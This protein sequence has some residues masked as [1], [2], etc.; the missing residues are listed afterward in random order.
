ML[1]A[2]RFWREQVS[3]L[4]YGKTG[5]KKRETC[6]AASLE[7][8]LMNNDVGR[9]TTHIKPVWQQIM[10]LTGLNMG[11]KTRNIF[12]LVDKSS[13]ITIFAFFYTF[14]FKSLF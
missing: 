7:N 13:R 9:Y 5:N 8:E 4:R 6:F 14:F 2:Q 10:L 11:G 12:Q 1:P 3:L